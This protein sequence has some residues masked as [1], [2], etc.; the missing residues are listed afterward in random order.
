M[1]SVESAHGQNQIISTQLADTKDAASDEK[2]D[3]QQQQVGDQ[4]INTQNG[5]NR[6]VVA[7]EIAQVVA[8]STLEFTKVGGL[9]KSSVIEKLLWRPY[10][11]N[12]RLKRSD[13]VAKSV[14][15][16][17]IRKLGKLKD[18]C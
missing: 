17:S 12:D 8:D 5:Y 14:K 1:R 7:L 2:N 18:R 3:K 6:D 9:G 11:G 16:E 4:G 10:F 13:I 15:I